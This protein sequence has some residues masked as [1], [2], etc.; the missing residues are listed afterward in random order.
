MR[1]VIACMTAGDMAVRIVRIALFFMLV[2]ALV[3][4]A[5]VG[6]RGF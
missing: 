2:A 3:A 4:T 5:G 6:V 1:R